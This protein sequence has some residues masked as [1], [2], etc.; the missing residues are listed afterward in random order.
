MV[1]VTSLSSSE[2]AGGLD[3]TDDR[4]RDRTQGSDSPASILFPTAIFIHKD[5]G[6]IRTEGAQ[7]IRR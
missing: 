1:L 7:E 2:E 5:A 3:F 4:T 6:K